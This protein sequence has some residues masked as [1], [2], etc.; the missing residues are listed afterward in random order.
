MHEQHRVELAHPELVGRGDLLES[1]ALGHA[2]ARK[3]ARGDDRR[4][5]VTPPGQPRDV[6]AVHVAEGGKR[7]GRGHGLAARTHRELGLVGRAQGKPA[8][9]GRLGEQPRPHEP[10]PE[11][12]GVNVAAH[13]VRRTREVAHGELVDVADAQ[14]PHELARILE[15]VALGAH[16]RAHA[17][18]PNGVDGKRRQGGRAKP[19]VHRK[20]HAREAALVHLVAKR[21]RAGIP[22]H[23]LAVEGVGVDGVCERALAHDVDIADEQ[24]LH[25]G[26]RHRRELAPRRHHE[27]AA[28]VH[29][30][31]VATHGTGCHQ[32]GVGVG[33]VLREAAV[34]HGGGKARGDVIGVEPVHRDVADDVGRDIARG[35]RVEVLE[36]E[37]EAHVDAAHRDA[38]RAAEGQLRGRVGGLGPR[39]IAVRDCRAKGPQPAREH[40]GKHGAVAHV[41]DVDAGVG[42]QP[43]HERHKG[44]HAEAFGKLAQCLGHV[45]DV[46]LPLGEAHGVGAH[47]RGR[48]VDEQ[49]GP[50]GRRALAVESHGIDGRG[51]VA[52]PRVHLCDGNPH[53]T[54]SDEKAGTG[55][56]A[57]YPPTIAAR[58]E[59]H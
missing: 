20:R 39:R 9:R 4:H 49:V 5:H 43:H 30:V 41:G 52:G 46:A 25:E 31:L 48:R 3:R 34:G 11:R 56:S 21:Q 6:G 23:A 42:A 54:S 36:G 51:K 2:D 44:G 58:R 45:E 53:G 33:G 59:R 37:G 1:Q 35:K 47:E 18:G 29:R 12:V 32:P 7:A 55:R 27:A 57:R 24:V 22:Q 26:G 17:Q 16:E 19:A 15:R 13:E 38:R 10:A 14:R 50:R 28:R 40:H 8:L